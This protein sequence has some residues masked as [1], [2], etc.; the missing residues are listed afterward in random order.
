FWPDG[1][2]S[3]GNKNL[4]PEESKNTELQFRGDIDP[5]SYYQVNIFYNEIENLI[6]WRYDPTLGD[7]GKFT[8][9]NVSEA[10]IRGIEMAYNISLASWQIAL[11]SSYIE[12]KDR[13]AD[14]DLQ[15][16]ARATGSVDISRR[17]D[18]YAMG[19]TITGKSER[20]GDAGTPGGYGTVDIRFERSFGESVIARLK[21]ENLF[22]REFIS[23]PGYNNTGRFALLELQYKL[24]H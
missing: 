14:V 8:P 4:K 20:K 15:R 5:Q 22:D 12:P 7:F 11:N 24:S 3:Q 21:V 10:R 2:F 16:R 13:T 18:D 23:V 17:G 6:D 19:L 9:S 1:L